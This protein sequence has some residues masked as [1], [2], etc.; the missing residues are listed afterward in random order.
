MNQLAK[1]GKLAHQPSLRH[2]RTALIVNVSFTI[3]ELIGGLWTNSMLILTDALHD[4]GDSV[5]LGIALYLQYY[6]RKGSDKKFTYGYRRFSIL[7]ALINGIILFGGSIFLIIELLHRLADPENVKADGMIGLA[8]LGIL[9]NG[10]AAWR[11]RQGSS[12]NERMAA[13]HLMEDVLGWIAVLIGSIVMYFEYIPILDPILSLGILTWVLFNVFRNMRDVFRVI[14]QAT[15]R[16]VDPEAI[17]REIEELPEIKTVQ[18]L[19]IWS[20]DGEY[21]IISLHVMITDHYPE[22]TVIKLKEKIRHIL[23]DESI[24]HVTIEISTDSEPEVWHDH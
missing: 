9:F 14:L 10:F 22:E 8:I 11:L 4:A 18:D 5:S 3:I 24:E 17:T 23:S 2:L 12:I 7:G 13:T 16:G 21:H 1:S 15:P 20:L 6:S 19:H